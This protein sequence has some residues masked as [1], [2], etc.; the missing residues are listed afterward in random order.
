MDSRHERI[1]RMDDGAH[2]SREKRQRSA[3]RRKVPPSGPH[4]GDSLRRKVPVDDGYVHAGLL[5]HVAILEHASDAAAALGPHPPVDAKLLVALVRLESVD[6]V[7]LDLADQKLHLGTG[8]A[9]VLLERVFRGDGLRE[10]LAE[11]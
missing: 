1:L 11:H 2:A 10:E 9:Q 7:G 5:K 8:G 4:L 6:K 3:G